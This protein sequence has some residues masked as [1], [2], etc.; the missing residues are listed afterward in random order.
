V[1]RGC[2]TRLAKKRAIT[3]HVQLS[4]ELFMPTLSVVLVR[5]FPID[6][7]QRYVRVIHCLK[8]RSNTEPLDNLHDSLFSVFCE[9]E[10]TNC[11]LIYKIIIEHTSKPIQ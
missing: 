2:L 1:D 3:K 4:Y 7:K 8:T 6:N 5:L 11:P 9:V 10:I